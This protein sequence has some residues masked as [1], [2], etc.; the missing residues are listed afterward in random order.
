MA[1]EENKLKRENKPNILVGGKSSKN[2]ATDQ[3]MAQYNQ[4]TPLNTNKDTILREACN[5]LLI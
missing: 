4:Y 2:N 5:L 1:I 3:I